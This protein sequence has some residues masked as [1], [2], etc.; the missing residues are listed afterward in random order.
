[1]EGS[2]GPMV[3]CAARSS[4]GFEGPAVLPSLSLLS[5]VSAF[6]LYANFVLPL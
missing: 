5:A 4:C 2:H 6:N 3:A 1:V